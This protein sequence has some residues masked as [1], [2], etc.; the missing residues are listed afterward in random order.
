MMVE[1]LVPAFGPMALQDVLDR[2]SAG[3]GAMEPFADDIVAFVGAFSRQLAG[4]PSTASFPELRALAFWT[5]PAGIRSLREQ[6]AGTTPSGTVRLPRGLVFHIP[7]SN[8]DTIFLY[9]WV[10]SALCGNQAIVRLPASRGAAAT[11]IC[12]VLDALLADPNTPGRIP[13]LAVITYGHDTD[14]TA[15][16]SARSDVRVIWGGD[17]TV[18]RIREVPLPPRATELTFADRYSFAIID[19][20]A[21]LAGDRGRRSRLAED[22]V[23]DTYLFDQGACSSPQMVVWRGDAARVAESAGVFF[24]DVASAAKTRG[25][26]ADASLGSAQTLAAAQLAIEHDVL[27]LRRFGRELM[28]VDI[29]SPADLAR[30]TVGGGYLLS[31]RVGSLD[32]LVPVLARTDQTIIQFGFGE[33]ELRAFANAAGAHGA[34]D[35]IVPIGQALAFDS[36]WDG[37][38]LLAAFTREVRVMSGAGR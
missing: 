34:I 14:I 2:L 20:K 11:I 37:Y 17:E 8:V 7:P 15:A 24:A 22:F 1:Q 10:L 28:V 30:V 29:A 23:G 26:G 5:R 4:H 33:E 13:G 3:G 16:I 38:D 21:Y 6:L 19:A 36:I 9:S 25:Y 35:R 12:E 32:E 27:G 18:R 31:T